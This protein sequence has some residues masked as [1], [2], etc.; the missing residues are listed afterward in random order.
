MR[1]SMR[2]LGTGERILATDLNTHEEGRSR[3]IIDNNEPDIVEQLDTVSPEEQVAL[4]ERFKVDTLE[5]AIWAARKL[6]AEHD[7]YQEIKKAYDTEKQRL[8]AWIARQ[9]KTAER[10]T[11]FF[12]GLIEEYHRIRLAQNSKDKKLDLIDAVSQARTYEA[13]VEIT[14]KEALLAYMVAN[15]ALDAEFIKREPELKWGDL[16]QVLQPVGDGAVI[17]GTG[18]I[19]PGVAVKPGETKI[20]VK[21]QD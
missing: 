11:G 16:K 10:H 21:V 1:E 14:D 15:E 2:E 18:E 5:K 13:S 9:K 3:M 19:I 8:D 12:A 6:K 20:T 4:K 17:I 7:K